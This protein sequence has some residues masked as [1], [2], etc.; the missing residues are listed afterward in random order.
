[1][2]DW[3]LKVVGPVFANKVP[4]AALTAWTCRPGRNN[5]P[6]PRWTVRAVGAPERVRFRPTPVMR[7]EYPPS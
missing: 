1:M 4:L 2:S 6:G 5:R 7:L 3:D